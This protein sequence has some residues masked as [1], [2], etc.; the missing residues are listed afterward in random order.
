MVFF[1]RTYYNSGVK[2]LTVRLPDSVFGEI[3]RVART[4]NI[5]KSEIIRERL[6]SSETGSRSLWS[7]MEDLVIHDNSLPTDL[8]SNK[9]HLRR[10][11]T[12]RYERQT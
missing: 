3:E 7:C 6:V 2:K 1:V 5:Y 10:Y 8:A 9:K 11:G 4:R 12:N